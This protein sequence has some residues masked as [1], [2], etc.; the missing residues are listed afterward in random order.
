[1][2]WE[3][4]WHMALPVCGPATSLA[5]IQADELAEAWEERLSV[6]PPSQVCPCRVEE[7]VAEEA[8]AP[9]S[10]AKARSPASSLQPW[11]SRLLVEGEEVDSVL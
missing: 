11:L 4:P 1:M 2:P 5:S 3:L 6:L 10:P 7:A 8:A 9:H